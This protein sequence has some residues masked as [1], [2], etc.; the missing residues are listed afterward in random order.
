M[1]F[2]HCNIMECC[3]LIYSSSSLCLTFPCI[4][5][6]AK[7]FCSFK[8]LRV[9]VIIQSNCDY[10]YTL[11]WSLLCSLVLVMLALKASYCT[12][13]LSLLDPITILN[14]PNHR[15]NPFF[16]PFFA[17]QYL[18]RLLYGLWRVFYPYVACGIWVCHSGCILCMYGYL[19]VV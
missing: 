8:K 12:L 4:E 1:V 3:V 19:K 13:Q 18:I 9:E 6:Q 10:L 16:F 7:S 5:T 2:A 11:K 15:G 17:H 14:R